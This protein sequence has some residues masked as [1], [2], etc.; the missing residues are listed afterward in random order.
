MSDYQSTYIEF[1]FSHA[2]HMH[3]SGALTV[4]TANC[5][6]GAYLKK[7]RFLKHAYCEQ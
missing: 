5:F 6:D 4:D 3:T 7:V 2:S 1:K